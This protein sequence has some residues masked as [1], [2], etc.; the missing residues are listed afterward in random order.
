MQ[1]IE[2]CTTASL[3]SLAFAFCLCAPPF[4]KKS[5][6]HANIVQIGGESYRLKDK[7]QGRPG[8]KE[9]EG[10]IG[11]GVGQK[12]CLCCGKRRSATSSASGQLES[13]NS[14]AKISQKQ[15]AATGVK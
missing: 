3:M 11:A 14:A 8:R 1:K 10:R 12:S 13:F 4:A 2:R 7:T 9:N 15:S 5:L 6:Q